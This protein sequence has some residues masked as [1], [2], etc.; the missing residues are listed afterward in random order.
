MT[1]PSTEL[2]TRYRSLPFP[3]DLLGDCTDN[4]AKLD[5]LGDLDD[6]ANRESVGQLLLEI[7]MATDEHDL[8]R[9]EAAKIVG[10]CVDNSSPL[11]HQLKQ[12]LWKIF[13]DTNDHTLV[14]QHASQ[15]ICAGFGGDSEHEVVERLLFDEEDDIDV[16]HGAFSYVSDTTDRLFVNRVVP[17]LQ[18]HEYW[19]RFP[20]SIPD[21]IA[22]PD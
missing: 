10:I 13:A 22:D 17:R 11:E 15:N 4:H 7:L 9:I 12:R 5:L 18:K 8:A 16:R 2:V 1:D 20:D 6:Y 19:S 3:S 14:R 21:L